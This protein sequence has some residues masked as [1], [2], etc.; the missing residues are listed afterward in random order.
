MVPNP[1]FLYHFTHI[2]NLPLIL[3]ADGLRTCGSLRQAG[4]NYKDVAYSTLQDRRAKTYVPCG[5]YGT[6]H[7]YVPFYFCPLSP[8][9][10][11]ISKG[12]VPG[13]DEGT[14]PLIFFVSTA[15]AVQ[16]AGLPFVFT[17][18]HGIMD[19]TGFYDDLNQLHQVDWPLMKA[20]MWKSTEAD[21]DRKRR[22]SAEFLVHDFMPLNLITHIG[23]RSPLI[24]A[25]VLARLSSIARH[26]EVLVRP[27]W[28]Y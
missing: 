14:R 21:P 11:T 25:T 12:N 10:F 23:T 17:D 27:G 22:R 4:V 6:L 3:A 13:Y 7:D 5:R 28:Y 8:M 24:Q 2:N 1:T 15:Q 18:G 19:Y 26:P 16:Q 9:L 20:T